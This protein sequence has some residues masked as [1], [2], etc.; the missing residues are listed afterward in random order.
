VIP[1][2]A[3]RKRDHVLCP[4]RRKRDPSSWLS[5]FRYLLVG[6]SVITSYVLLLVIGVL[7]RT[8]VRAACYIVATEREAE[9]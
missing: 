5:S 8:T 1:P 7:R 6:A 4:A 2:P 3:R 9:I